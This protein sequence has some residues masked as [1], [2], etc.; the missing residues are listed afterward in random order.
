[1]V[2]DLGRTVGLR[3]SQG[4]AARIA[5]GAAN[6]QAIVMQELKKLGLYLAASPESPK[7]LDHEAVDEVGAAVPEGDFQRLADLALGGEVAAL[8]TALDQL[9]SGGGETIPTVRSVQRRLQML[10][11]MRARIEAGESLD[12]V[13]ASAGKALFWKD[14]PVVGKL[15]TTWDS[16]RLAK[17]ADRIGRLERD[18][19]LSDVPEN[20]GLGEAMLAVGRAARGRR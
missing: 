20:A 1:M 11:P 2:M 8:S 16:E 14:K 17:V 18:L 13:M 12:A 19:L 15:L 3:M 5:E 4:V 7:E 10:A 6:D 9:A